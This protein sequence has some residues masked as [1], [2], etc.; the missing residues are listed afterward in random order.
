[1]KKVINLF[2]LTIL[3]AT[4]LLQSCKKEL[5]SDFTSELTPNLENANYNYAIPSKLTLSNDFF[6]VI[7]YNSLVPKDNPITDAGAQLGRVLFY[8]KKM[9]LNGKVS[10]GSCHIQKFAFSDGNKTSVGFDGQSTTRNSPAIINAIAQKDYFWDGRS[11]KLEEMVLMPVRNHVEMGIDR[12]E[13]LAKRISDISYYPALF[14]SAFGS[15]EVTK[16]KISKA[17]S[18]FIR[19]MVTH[20]TSYDNNNLTTEEQSGRS[21]FYWG[22]GCGNCHN[23]ENLNSKSNFNNLGSGINFAN[24]GLDEVSIDK[25]VGE[26]DENKVGLFKIPSLRNIALTAPYMHDG[27]FKTLEEVVE[28]YNSGVKPH[29]NLDLALR[30]GWDD[31][32]LPR[33][34]NLSDKQKSSLVAFLKSLTDNKLITDKRFSDPFIQ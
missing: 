12:I 24:I 20:N 17:L 14:E 22:A 10:C 23:G 34:L 11:K 2:F 3:F 29:K 31:N 1:M 25:G 15:K 9:S 4:I 16:D 8:D 5:K 27:R 30:E 32:S 18:Q 13:N 21:L 28:H 6:S 7:D 19:S 26:T 33:K